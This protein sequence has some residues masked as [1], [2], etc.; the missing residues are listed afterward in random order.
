LGE[1]EAV[2]AQHPA[3]RESV[4]IVKEDSAGV[5][6]LVAYI[7]PQE[8]APATSELGVYLKAKLPNY[9]VPGAV[10]VLDAIPFTANGKVDRQALPEPD[11]AFADSSAYV[12][13]RNSIEESIA[14]IWAE[15]LGVKQIGVHDNFFDLGGHSL[16]ATQVVSRLRKVFDSEIPL[17]HLFECPTVEELAAV[18]DSKT[19]DGLNSEKLDRLLIE[20]EEMSE[21]EL[22]KLLAHKTAARRRD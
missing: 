1:I 2:L 21:E 11:R 3:V 22:Q 16:K 8:A 18:I 20:V 5:Q 14:G 7:V 9:M 17:R 12:G 19:I 4:V 15:I 10:V 13:P 6:R